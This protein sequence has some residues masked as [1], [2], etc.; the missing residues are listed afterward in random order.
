MIKI[1]YF[2]QFREQLGI[3]SEQ[4][5]LPRH[6]HTVETLLAYLRG[7]GGNW[8][9]VFGADAVVCV[10]VNHA[11]VAGQGTVAVGDEIAFFPPVTGG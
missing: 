3:D 1:L 4:I 5:Q 10:A 7:R 9:E 11:M 2:A 8:T 6:V